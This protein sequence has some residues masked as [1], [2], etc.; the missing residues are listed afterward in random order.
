LKV[1]SSAQSF[2][3]GPVS[4]LVSLVGYLENTDTAFIGGEGAAKYVHL[5]GHQFSHIYDEDGVDVDDRRN[6][7]V[8]ADAVLSVME[9]R[10]VFEA[11]RLGRPVVFVDSLFV[12]WRQKHT[13]PEL[14]VIA[15][16]IRFGTDLESEL[17]IQSLSVHESMLVCHLVA[18]RSIAQVFPGVEDRVSEFARMDRGSLALTGSLIDPRLHRSVPPTQGSHSRT[19]VINLGGFNNAFLTYESNGQYIN[20]LLRWIEE[21][22]STE[23]E[24]DDVYVCS[25]AFDRDTEQV[26]A[27]TRLHVGLLPHDRLMEL[28]AHHPVYLAPP[29][30]TSL[31]EAAIIGVPVMLLPDQHYGHTQNRRRLVGTYLHS[32]G[33]SFERFGLGEEIP[34]DDF[35][36]TLALAE[37]ADVIDT[38]PAVFDRFSSQMTE[39]LLGFITRSVE[40]RGTYISEL[41]ELC[42]GPNVA[43]VMVDIRAQLEVVQ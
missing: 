10:I 32:S 4:K 26:V 25:G 5:N 30:L 9:P 14:R 16:T 28:L 11:V 17:A 3:F 20:V 43:G 29:G 15:D 39:T 36:G 22:L 19:M 34:E 6:L 31:H 7:I 18:M 21:F 12:F 38:S 33:A 42:S 13:W 24:F 35:A 2:G 27:G 1:L 23:T 40:E 41:V 37:L 8:Q